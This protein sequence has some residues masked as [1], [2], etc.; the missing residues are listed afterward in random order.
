[1]RIQIK[2]IFKCFQGLDLIYSK[3]E[4]EFSGTFD[5]LMQSQ[6]IP[7]LKEEVHKLQGYTE[8][9]R[10][11]LA[12]QHIDIPLQKVP[13]DT[14][15][16][17]IDRGVVMLID[18]L[19]EGN[20]DGR[21]YQSQTDYDSLI[22]EISDEEKLTGRESADLLEVFNVNVNSAENR[23]EN[24]DDIA[25]KFK[26]VTGKKLDTSGGSEKVLDRIYDAFDSDEYKVIT[27]KIE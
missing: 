21:Q 12:D 25:S 20:V 9:Q 13:V 1:M 4:A 2:D 26:E 10:M 23:I 19:I 27:N 15:P 6:N 8:K 24:I 16:S 17:K 11:E 5:Y 7:V 3:D 18:A 22:P 14:L